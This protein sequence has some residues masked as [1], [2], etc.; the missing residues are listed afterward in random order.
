MAAAW[1]GLMS[2]PGVAGFFANVE[3]PLPAPV[4]ATISTIRAPVR[5]MA[6]LAQGTHDTIIPHV[7]RVRGGTPPGCGHGAT[8]F[9]RRALQ[10]RYS[11][12]RQRTRARIQQLNGAEKPR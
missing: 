10:N 12:A 8:R 1:R 2:S 9:R 7:R 4:H 3:H 6:S 11:F 5:I